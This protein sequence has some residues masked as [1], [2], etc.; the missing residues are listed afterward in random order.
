MSEKKYYYPV[1]SCDRRS[2]IV[3]NPSYWLESVIF[4]VSVGGLFK[5]VQ[6]VIS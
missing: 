5:V 1:N 3:I 6:E 2:S 4:L